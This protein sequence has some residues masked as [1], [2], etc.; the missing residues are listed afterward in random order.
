M[1]RILRSPRL[2]ETYSK[3]AEWPCNVFSVSFLTFLCHCSRVV[4]SSPSPM[5]FCLYIFCN[6]NCLCFS[7]CFEY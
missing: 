3:D 4:L 5:Y 7:D 2:N 1:S 6:F